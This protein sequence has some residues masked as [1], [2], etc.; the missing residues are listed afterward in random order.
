MEVQACPL[1]GGASAPLL[2]TPGQLIA[3]NFE[4]L[5][6]LSHDA[7]QRLKQW[8]EDGATIYVRGA[9]KPGFAYSLMPFSNQCF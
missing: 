6:R 4:T 7:R 2:A 9:L 3:L 1:D 5:T 8:A